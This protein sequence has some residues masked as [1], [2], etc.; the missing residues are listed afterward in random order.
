M[1][2]KHSL[3]DIWCIRVSLFSLSWLVIANILTSFASDALTI[4]IATV[5]SLVISAK[6]SGA[7]N[8]FLHNFLGLKR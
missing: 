7:T 2:K 3:L 4:A 8:L 5:I 1:G 6:L